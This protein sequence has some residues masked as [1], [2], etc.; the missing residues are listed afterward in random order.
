MSTGTLEF[1][2]PFKKQEPT[3]DG[4]PNPQG[5]LLPKCSPAAIASTNELVCEDQ[6]ATAEIRK[7]RGASRKLTHSITTH[8]IFTSLGWGPLIWTSMVFPALLEED[9]LNSAIY[10]ALNNSYFH[11]GG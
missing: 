8:N 5:L 1:L 7:N 4:L 3:H 11:H 9:P 6:Q 10:L 2:K